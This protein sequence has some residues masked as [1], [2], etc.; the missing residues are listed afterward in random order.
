M[1]FETSFDSKQSKLKK[2]RR[3]YSTADCVAPRSIYSTADCATFCGHA[4]PIKIAKLD[5]NRNPLKTL[6]ST[7]FYSSLAASELVWSIAACD[8]SG[9]IWPTAACAVLSLNVL[10]CTAAYAAPGGFCYTTAC[11]ALDVS[12]LQQAVLPLD[13]SVQQQTV[14]PGHVFSR[15]PYAVH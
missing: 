15:V 12:V 8:A 2:Y 1:S 14:L 3:I 10:V 9:R 11:A 7:V 4:Y 13:L 6:V 5:C